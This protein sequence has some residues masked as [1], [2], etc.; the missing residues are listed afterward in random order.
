MKWFNRAYVEA[1]KRCLDNPNPMV[2]F[3]TDDPAYIDSAS[4]LTKLYDHQEREKL[5]AKLKELEA[6][7]TPLK[8]SSGT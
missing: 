1:I 2:R 6:L 7:S 5:R 4:V 8:S 3:E